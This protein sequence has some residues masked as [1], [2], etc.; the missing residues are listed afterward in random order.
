MSEVI[1]VVF[2]EAEV[3]NEIEQ[4][5]HALVT[6]RNGLVLSYQDILKTDRLTLRILRE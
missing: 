4:L 6:Y 2:S 1:C 3:R 5:A